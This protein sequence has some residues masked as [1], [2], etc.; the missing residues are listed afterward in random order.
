MLSLSHWMA[1]LLDAGPLGFTAF[2]FSFTI[3]VVIALPT[4]PV[5][6][7]A[8]F[9]YGPFWGPISGLLCKTMGSFGALSIAR[10]F[11]QHRGWEI[12]RSLRCKLDML[13][14]RPIL[15][16]ISVRLAPLPLA[17]K[18]YGLAF[19][20]VGSMDYVVASALVNGPFSIA[21][22]M[23]GAS[24]QSL[25]DATN[26]ANSSGA[27]SRCLQSLTDPKVGAAFALSVLVLYWGYCLLMPLGKNIHEKPEEDSM[28]QMPESVQRQR[29]ATWPLAGGAASKQQD[30]LGQSYACC[31]GSQDV[32]TS[33]SGS[34]LSEGGSRETNKRGA[35]HQAA[36]QAMVACSQA[37]EA[38]RAEP[39]T[40]NL[41]L[42]ALERA[43]E[44]S[45][46]TLQIARRALLRDEMRAARD[47]LSRAVVSFFE[48]PSPKNPQSSEEVPKVQN[49]KVNRSNSEDSDN[50][51]L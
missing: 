43:A 34:P 9:L 39:E 6:I 5:E 3:W 32:H 37:L 4:T 47:D 13:Q 25:A 14:T 30:G 11:G 19:T 49:V 26:W 12:P 17:V 45:R 2:I 1:L 35:V 44:E 46:A 33:L 18:N 16:M 40:P 28:H 31:Y 50:S 23:I 29:A 8:G 41:V 48:L 22:G 38:G 36:R 24:C 20:D 27:N 42:E 51:N 7:A 15:T 21:W 10:L